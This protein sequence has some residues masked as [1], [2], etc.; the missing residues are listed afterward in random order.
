MVPLRWMVSRF[1]NAFVGT[2]AE[3]VGRISLYE[4]PT[5]LLT[6]ENF[7]SFVR[8]VREIGHGDDG[9]VIYSGGFPSRP[10]MEAIARLARQAAVS[11][12][13][14]GIWTQAASVSSAT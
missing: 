1:Q 3:C 12:F 13:H 5:Y 14:W 2:P 10:V 7:A 11:T 6:I 4:R 9:L 8:Y